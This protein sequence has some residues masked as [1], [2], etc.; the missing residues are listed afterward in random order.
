MT[1]SFLDR[2]R[3]RERELGQAVIDEQSAIFGHQTLPLVYRLERTSFR[4]Q[5]DQV[6]IRI[7]A[8]SH[9]RRW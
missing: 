4:E 2:P 6:R 1:G 7:A 9:R 3:E 5:L 8:R